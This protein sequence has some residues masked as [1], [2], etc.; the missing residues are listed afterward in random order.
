M[1]AQMQFILHL[2]PIK[3]LLFIHIGKMKISN[4]FICIYIL[5]L[6]AFEQHECVQS[7]FQWLAY[8]WKLNLFKQFRECITKIAKIQKAKNK[9]LLKIKKK[10]EKAE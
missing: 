1:Q 8:M 3:I 10:G 4:R 9:I 7:Q 2:F 6:I 5:I